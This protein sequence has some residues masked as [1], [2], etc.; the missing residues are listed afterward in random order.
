[1]AAHDRIVQEHL[2]ELGE[3]L[4]VVV[5]VQAFVEHIAGQVTADEKRVPRCSSPRL[6]DQHH[7]KIVSGFC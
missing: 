4:D 6:G 5:F 7:N 2:T 1:M 3:H